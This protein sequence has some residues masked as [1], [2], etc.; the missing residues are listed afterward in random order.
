[1]EPFPK[2]KSCVQTCIKTNDPVYPVLYCW[3]NLVLFLHKFFH[4]LWVT[5]QMTEVR[6]YPPLF[7]RFWEDP[8]IYS[9][10]ENL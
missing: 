3:L 8:V 4:G 10:V 1:M 9:F 2:S 6:I 7:R 5:L